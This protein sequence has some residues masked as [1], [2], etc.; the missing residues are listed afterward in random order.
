LSTDTTEAFSGWCLESSGKGR[1][2][3]GREHHVFDYYSTINKESENFV[4]ALDLPIYG[5]EILNLSL[6]Q[7]K[8]SGSFTRRIQQ[9]RTTQKFFN[10]WQKWI[11]ARNRGVLPTSGI[12][13]QGDKLIL[14][15]TLSANESVT[16][17]LHALTNDSYFARQTLKYRHSATNT[18]MTLE[19]FTTECR[20]LA[21]H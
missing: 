6:K 17:T 4:V 5:E 11:V 10:V 16:L 12:E 3:L 13:L 20:N 8:I 14:T 19:M 15:D 7:Q 9:T 2:E 1:I 21:A 18:E